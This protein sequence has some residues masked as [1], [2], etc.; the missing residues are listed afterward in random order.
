MNHQ[1]LTFTDF[2]GRKVWIPVAKI[3]YVEHYHGTNPPG[4]PGINGVK[5][6]GHIAMTNKEIQ[7]YSADAWPEIQKQLEIDDK[8]VPDLTPDKIV[9][10]L[11]TT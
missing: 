6:V 3:E 4:L 9:P 2:F 5:P 10:M 11:T 1:Y 8:R 7:W